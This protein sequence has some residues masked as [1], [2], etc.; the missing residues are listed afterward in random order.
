M[1]LM[2]VLYARVHTETMCTSA[3][4]NLHEIDAVSVL[5]LVCKEL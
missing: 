4:R 1:R 5:Q 2:S 3:V